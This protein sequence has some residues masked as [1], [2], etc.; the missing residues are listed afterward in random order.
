MR[1]VVSYDDITPPEEPGSPSAQLGPP[2]PSTNQPPAKKRKMH[3]KTQQRRPPPQ[4]VQHWDEPGSSADVMNYQDDQG[5]EVEP[6]AARGRAPAEV[7]EGEEEE[8]EQESRDLTHEEIWD[9]SALIDAW[10]SANAEYEVRAR[11][12]PS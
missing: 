7:E 9:D 1:P 6:K 10:N 5:Y 4:H 2:I 8:E 3:Q 12:Q 11:H